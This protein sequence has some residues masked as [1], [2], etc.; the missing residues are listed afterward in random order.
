[1]GLSDTAENQKAWMGG[2]VEYWAT[3]GLLADRAAYMVPGTDNRLKSGQKLGKEYVE[4]QM[5]VVRRRVCQ[6]GLRLA[7]VLN[8]GFAVK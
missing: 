1:M 2:T 5:P 7:S 4:I 3:E 6:A 8:G